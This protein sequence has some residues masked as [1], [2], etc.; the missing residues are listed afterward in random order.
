MP[1]LGENDSCESGIGLGCKPEDR[2]A[3]I[4]RNHRNNAMK[5]FISNSVLAAGLM[6]LS[7][8]GYGQTPIT[9]VPYTISAP[10][11]YILANNLTYFAASKKPTP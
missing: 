3:L 4:V 2:A 9:S 11:K 1:A 10:G 7:V 6:L 8:A 5:C